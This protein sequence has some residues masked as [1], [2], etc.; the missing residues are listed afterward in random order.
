MRPTAWPPALLGVVL[1][2]R[3]STHPSRPAKPL[4]VPARSAFAGRN[5][6]SAARSPQSNVRVGWRPTAQPE[7]L[8]LLFRLSHL[9]PCTETLGMTM[10]RGILVHTRG[11]RETSDGLTKQNIANDKKK[12]IREIIDCIIL[13]LCICFHWCSRPRVPER[14]SHSR[15]HIDYNILC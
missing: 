1:S 13:N 9:E 4:L 3:T 11:T 10:Q 7:V 15:L 2:L 12:A 5:C 8:C 6:N 14:P